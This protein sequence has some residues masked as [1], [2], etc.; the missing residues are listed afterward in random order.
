MHLSDVKVKDD[1]AGEIS[2]KLKRGTYLNDYCAAHIPGYDSNRLE[3]LAIRLFYGK[4]IIVTIYAADKARIK[5]SALN[6]GKIPVKKFKRDFS[7]LKNM[8][9]WVSKCNFTLITGQYP[10]EEME[11]INK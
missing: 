4:E 6:P 10:I 5:R 1:L 9:P 2:L 3:V 11:V 7:F 8:L